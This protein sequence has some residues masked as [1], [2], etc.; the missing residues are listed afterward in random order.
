MKKI[1]LLAVAAVMIC[2]VFAGCYMDGRGTYYPDIAEMKDA[3]DDKG[4]TVTTDTIK[5]E[6]EEISVLKA[7]KKDEFIVFYRFE[8]DKYVGEYVD[9][10]KKAHSSYDYLESVTNDEKHGNIAYCS[11][12][13]ARDH[14]GIQVVEV[15][16]N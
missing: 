15:K 7:D 1:V 5:M 8:T 6:D 16:N 10:M 12:K 14:A 4:Y 11:T 13:K 9:E 3:L 2:L